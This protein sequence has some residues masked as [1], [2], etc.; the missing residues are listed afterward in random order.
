MVMFSISESGER[1]RAKGQEKAAAALLLHRPW[2]SP[3]RCVGD[4]GHLFGVSPTGRGNNLSKNR[5]FRDSS[6]PVMLP[7]LAL[8]PSFCLTSVQDPGVRPWELEGPG[9]V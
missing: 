5:P 3:H 1:A 6:L 9:S 4:G 8:L 7:Q 2:Q